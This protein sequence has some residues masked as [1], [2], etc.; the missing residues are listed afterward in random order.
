MI[1]LQRQRDIRKSLD[2]NTLVTSL[3]EPNMLIYELKEEDNKRRRSA[4]LEP[5]A[6]LQN[7]YEETYRQ[8][9]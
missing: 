7:K 8:H 6:G 5:I 1:S 4:L 2:Q 3:G 9:L